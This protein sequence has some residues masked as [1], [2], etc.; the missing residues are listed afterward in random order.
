[1][2]YDAKVRWKMSGNICCFFMRFANCGI[3]CSK[4]WGRLCCNLFWG[5][6]NVEESVAREESLY[7]FILFWGRYAANWRRFEQAQKIFFC[8]L[9]KNLNLF[10]P[11]NLCCKLSR[12]MRL[13]SGMRDLISEIRDQEKAYPVSGSMGNQSIVSRIRIRN[14]D[15]WS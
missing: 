13:V 15:L 3:N 2:R 5:M 1:M 14:T 12:N 8:E 6:Q 10:N 11:K 9:T 7:Y 4:K